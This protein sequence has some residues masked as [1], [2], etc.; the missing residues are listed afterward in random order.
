MDFFLHFFLLF[1]IFCFVYGFKLIISKFYYRMEVQLIFVLSEE[2][3]F[4]EIEIK[5]NGIWIIIHRIKELSVIYCE[6]IYFHWYIIHGTYTVYFST[7]NRL[8]LHHTSWRM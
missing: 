1:R 6:V 5:K 8:L 7:Y 2:I 4:K 3:V